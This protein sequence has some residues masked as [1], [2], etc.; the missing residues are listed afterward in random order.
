MAELE[1][2]VQAFHRAIQVVGGQSALGRLIGK[3]QST[4]WE[5]VDRKK[6]L[7]AEFVLTIE[8]ATGISRHELR[9]DIYPLELAP[10]PSTPALG[11][12]LPDGR[13]PACP[14][15]GPDPVPADTASHGE[16]AGSGEAAGS[17]TCDPR[18]PAANSVPIG[19]A[20]S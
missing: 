3:P 20:A 7:P 8:H 2:S 18:D 12:S 14:S 4:V 16:C 11:S 6:P 9:P 13:N 19:K 1:S 15:A 5:W 17:L 10:A